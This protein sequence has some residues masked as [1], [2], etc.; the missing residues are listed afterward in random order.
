MGIMPDVT[1]LPVSVDLRHLELSHHLSS[2]GERIQVRDA[3]AGHKL[4]TSLSLEGA[5]RI[6]ALLRGGGDMFAEFVIRLDREV[7]EA[8]YAT[9]AR[10]QHR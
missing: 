5:A 1:N 9:V 10:A 3:R 6:S 8:V 7:A 2:R 4:I